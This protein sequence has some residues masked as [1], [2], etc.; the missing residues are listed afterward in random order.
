MANSPQQQLIYDWIDG[1]L[2]AE[3]VQRAQRLI[4]DDHELAELH[5]SLRAQQTA[6]KQLPTYKLD[7]NFADRVL[8]AA[9]AKGLLEDNSHSSTVKLSLPTNNRKWFAPIAAITSLAAMLL[10]TLFVI[11]RLSQPSHASHD[12]AT[13][14]SIADDSSKQSNDESSDNET[15]EESD[16]PKLA[17][18]SAK[19]AESFSLPH[20]AQA[21]RETQENDPNAGAGSNNPQARSLPRMDSPPNRDGHFRVQPEG[22]MGDAMPMAMRSAPGEAV[23]ER[24]QMLLAEPGKTRART[25]ALE[26][27]VLVFNVSEKEDAILR[28]NKT[29]ADNGI[30]AK[31]P[32][33]VAARVSPVEKGN[34]MN[35][36]AE[37]DM[38]EQFEKR[39]FAFQ[40]QASPG[41][42][43]EVVLA[44]RNQTK[45][46]AVDPGES[47]AAATFGQDAQA[48]VDAGADD[49]NAAG[50]DDAAD[51]VAQNQGG[52][53]E[54]RTKNFGNAESL[55]AMSKNLAADSE[56]A[57]LNEMPEDIAEPSVQEIGVKDSLNRIR[58]INDFFGL[59]TEEQDLQ[60]YTLIFILD[61]SIA[62][63]LPA[64]SQ[65]ADRSNESENQAA[66]PV[67]EDRLP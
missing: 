46:V 1:Q 11:P 12:P 26:N 55:R 33:T 43:Q 67:D 10:I 28:L 34:A 24:S 32:A 27:Q 66:S 57:V 19:S 51:S 8:Q 18:K 59:A 44:L 30:V 42:M 60:T 65:P 61:R 38:A 37:G 40:V 56:G 7:A 16:T 45:I 22:A 39:E 17:M 29:L 3:Q 41:Q 48:A 64:E 36:Q 62:E 47:L 63:A 20:G 2:S 35:R 25:K 58:E 31:L 54:L 49:E 4:A 50:A 23:P 5:E 52:G 21:K 6:L 9:Q 53:H 13:K 15:E 14:D